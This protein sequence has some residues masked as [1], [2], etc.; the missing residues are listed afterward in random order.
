[1]L[2]DG[3]T[4]TSS[5]EVKKKFVLRKMTSY[6]DIPKLYTECDSNHGVLVWDIVNKIHEYFK[7]K[8][9]KWTF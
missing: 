5:L 3:F 2:G 9:R 1:M 7:I 6:F 8:N 4:N